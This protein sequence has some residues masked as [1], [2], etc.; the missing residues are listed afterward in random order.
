MPLPREFTVAIRYPLLSLL[1]ALTLA[2]A[3]AGPFDGSDALI[4][5]IALFRAGQLSQARIEFERLAEGGEAEAQRYLG[6]FYRSGRGGVR[7]NERAAYWYRKAA[8]QGV[9]E[10]QYELGLM[11]ELGQGVEPDF[12]EAEY[13]YGRVVAQGFCPSELD[14]PGRLRR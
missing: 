8:E 2:P 10:A 9:P 12:W 5:A 7:D 1:I 13:W 3:A 6:W 11:Y 4:D 14:T